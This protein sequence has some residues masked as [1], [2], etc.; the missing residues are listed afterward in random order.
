M[1]GCLGWR[2]YQTAPNKYIG[3]AFRMCGGVLKNLKKRSV[4][5]EKA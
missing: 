2:G 3:D 4:F 5:D 1:P